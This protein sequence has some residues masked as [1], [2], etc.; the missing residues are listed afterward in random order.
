MEKGK[1]YGGTSPLGHLYS[2]DTK[3]GP[4]GMLRHN[5]C[6]CFS[7]DTPVQGKRTLFLRVPKPDFN[8]LSGDRLLL[9]K[10]TDHKKG[11]ISSIV[12]Q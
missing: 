6:V 5:L 11:F 1:I 10:V 4:E 9:K 2:V 8:P 3:F 12:H 7:R